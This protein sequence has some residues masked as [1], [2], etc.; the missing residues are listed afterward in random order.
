[1]SITS[2]T[3]DWG[4][5]PAIVRI[6]STDSYAAVTADG[7]LTAQAANIAAYNQGSFE[8]DVSD[9]VLIYYADGWSFLH[10]NPTFTSLLPLDSISKTASVT[11]SA[12]QVLAAYATPQLLIPAPGASKVIV[13]TNSAMY[14]NKSTA[15]AAGGAGI[16][17]YG[18]T[19]NG[20]GTQALDGTIAATVINNA[21]SR[22]YVQYGP[23]TTT[24]LTGV[25]NAGIYFSNQTAAFTTGTGSSLTFNLEYMVV[26]A[27]V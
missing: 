15:F 20:G 17:Q 14:L 16:V 3:R 26:N 23:V 5:N 12:A 1:M 13:L 24:A 7:Y 11:L 6:T 25:S 21:A 19:V 22:V 9:A 10:V 2:I 18:A 4:F 8:W 27:L